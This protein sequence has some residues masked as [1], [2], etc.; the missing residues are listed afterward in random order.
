MVSRLCSVDTR[1]SGV[2]GSFRQFTAS[3]AHL[4]KVRL[5]LNPQRDFSRQLQVSALCKILCAKKGISYALHPRTEPVQCQQ[6][7]LS[8]SVLCFCQILVSTRLLSG[9]DR[10]I[11][12]APFAL[13]RRMQYLSF[14]SL[15]SLRR[16]GVPLS[17]RD[18]SCQSILRTFGYRSYV[19]EAETCLLVIASSERFTKLAGQLLRVVLYNICIYILHTLC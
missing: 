7:M 18:Y 9:A 15:C 2:A 1:N 3:T 17:L 8:V 10:A 19:P 13:V 6:S 14:L 4:T 5:G 11:E 16:N 12:S